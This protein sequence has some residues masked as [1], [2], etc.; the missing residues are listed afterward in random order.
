MEAG[1]KPSGFQQKAGT[2]GDRSA[3]KSDTG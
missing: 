2:G 3:E 1:L